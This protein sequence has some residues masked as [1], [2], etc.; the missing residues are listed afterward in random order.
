MSTAIP[1]TA[2]PATEP[3]LLGAAERG[4]IPDAVL[5]WGIRRL[6]AQRLREESDGG[7]ARQSRIFSERIAELAG[8]PLA[9]HVDAANRQH[10]E[11]PAAFFQACLGPRMKYSSC[12]YRSG[13]ETLAE[14][15]LAMLELY[16]QRAELADGQDILELGCGWG[17]LT[18][19]MAERFPRANITAVSNSSSQRQHIQAQCLA[20]GLVNVQVITRDVNQLDLPAQAFDRCVSV[21]MFEHMRNYGRLLR[22][23]AGWLRP[24]GA[25]FVHIF[26]HRTLMY[27]FDSDGEDNWMGRHFFTGGLMPAADTL[28]HFQH[29]LQLQQRWLLEGSHY[30]RTANHWLAN[31]DRQRDQLMPVLQ[32]TYGD[33]ADIWWQRWRM[34]WMA[35]AELFGYDDGQQWLV[36][37]YLFRPR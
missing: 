36:A 26:A 10:Y 7:L 4:W 29:D 30:Q 37:H 6:C 27:P 28:L 11:V 33:A 35:C 3:G 17:S 12:Y 24:Q 14:A 13:H 15:E 18:L 8:S 25:L 19:W 16:A 20:R 21:E 22:N 34:F 23:I 2:V 5:R 9:L 1:T 31:Q 32:A